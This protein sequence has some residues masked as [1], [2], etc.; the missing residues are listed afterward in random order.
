MIRFRHGTIGISFAWW[1]FAIPSKAFTHIF[2]NFNIQRLIL[3]RHRLLAAL[4]VGWSPW[5]LGP[6]WTA[7]SSSSTTSSTT[8]R[9][10]ASTPWGWRG[11]PTRTRGSS[12]GRGLIQAL[13]ST[14]PRP[15]GQIGEDLAHLIKRTLKL[16]FLFH[17]Y[18]FQEGRIYSSD[19]ERPLRLHGDRTDHCCQWTLVTQWLQ[20]SRDAWYLWIWVVVFEKQ[21][22]RYHKDV[23]RGA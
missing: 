22:T 19:S 12:S 10:W 21:Q 4:S 2:L 7:W 11:R 17:F 18:I 15:A 13:I 8:P 16:V 23:Y 20:Q 14:L 6:S 9:P 3:F 5:S 1:V